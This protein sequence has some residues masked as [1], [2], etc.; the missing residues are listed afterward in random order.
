MAAQNDLVSVL[1]Q[2]DLKLVKI[3]SIGERPED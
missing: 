2:F 3:A 1:G